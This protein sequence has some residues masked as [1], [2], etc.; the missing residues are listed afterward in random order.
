MTDAPEAPEAVGLPRR[1]RPRSHA[2]RRLPRDPPG[3]PRVG[4]ARR[5][6]P[7]PGARRLRLRP[8]LRRLRPHAGEAGWRVVAWD[9][10][11]HGDSQHAALYSWEA[12][13]RDAVAVVDSVSRDPLPVVG[14]SK[15]GGITVQFASALPHR[16]SHLVNL[17][18]C[19]AAATCPT[20]RP[21]AH[22]AAGRRAGDWLDFRRS[23][24]GRQRRPGTIDEL[25][26]RRE[27]MNPR[28]SRTG[29]AT[30][31]PWAAAGTP[32]A[33]AGRS[34]RRSAWAASARGASNGRWPGCRGW[35]AAAGRAGAATRD[36]GVRDPARRH[37]TPLPSAAPG[38]GLE[39]TATSC[40]S[41]S[42]SGAADLVLDSGLRRDAGPCHRH[43]PHS[44][45][46][47]ALT[48]SATAT[49]RR[50]APPARAGGTLAGRPAR[51]PGGLART[52]LGARL[53]RARR[54][55]HAGRRRLLW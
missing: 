22:Q 38:S 35:H 5:P 52:G 2:G 28:L 33:G 11:G 50:V 49:G 24:V 34:T 31:S 1:P 45:I 25:A 6:A 27:A 37:R 7:G 30:W 53:H 13:L 47:L 32:T 3:R 46:E 9:Q 18:G 48:A 26:E 21:R 23:V 10:R 16:V 8:H 55:E 43:R 17:D 14:H 51:S 20:S 36:H 44:R 29:S 39:D 40:T 15:G 54:A 42:P 4:R 12:D 19:P 41:N